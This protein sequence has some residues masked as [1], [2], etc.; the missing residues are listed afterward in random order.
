ME[1]FCE[2]MIAI[3]LTWRLFG[4]MVSESMTCKNG[5]ERLA[6]KMILVAVAV[7]SILLYA[8]AGCFDAIVAALGG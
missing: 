1:L 6:A 8:G 4:M 7:S 3:A 5:G 2:V